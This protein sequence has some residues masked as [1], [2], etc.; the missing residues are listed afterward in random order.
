MVKSMLEV[1]HA[2]G[3]KEYNRRDKTGEIHVEKYW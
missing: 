2:E 3:F 1:L